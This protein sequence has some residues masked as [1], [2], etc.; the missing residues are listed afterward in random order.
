[1]ADAG[2]IVAGAKAYPDRVRVGVLAAGID[3]ATADTTRQAATRLPY[4][5]AAVTVASALVLLGAAHLARSGRPSSRFIATVL[6]GLT[7]L[8]GVG[9][10]AQS[11]T[12]TPTGWAKF[13]AYA[14]GAGGTR[15]FYQTLPEGYP[16]GERILSAAF[17]AVAMVSLIVATILLIRLDR[18]PPGLDEIRDA[19]EAPG[20][21]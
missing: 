19:Q 13:S 3:P 15:I 8:I 5:A 9:A 20:R 17:G 6:C 7:V 16:A 4:V 18:R 2:V 12:A 1:V 11:G 21:I 10:A 14:H